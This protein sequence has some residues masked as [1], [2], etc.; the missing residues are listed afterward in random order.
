M[1]DTDYGFFPHVTR[2]SCTARNAIMLLNTLPFEF[3]I[4]T[5]YITRAY[6]TRH[7]NGYMTNQDLD[8]EYII[9]NPNETN[10]SD[11]MQGTFRKSVLDLD[12]L[13]YAIS[14][15]KYEN[16]DSE[17]TMVV[18]CLDQVPAK[19][20]VTY[21]GKLKEMEWDMIPRQIGIINRMGSW[22]EEGYDR[23]RIDSFKKS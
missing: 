21:G 10:T 17:R 1:L 7:G 14:C 22:S 3:N 13:K 16:P 4:H 12:L 6:Q 20:P 18:T 5:Y 8:N 15:D 2:S 23:N 11:G 9:D 19:I